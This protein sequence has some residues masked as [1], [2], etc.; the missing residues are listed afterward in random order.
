MCSVLF[1]FHFPVHTN[2][3]VKLNKIEEEDVEERDE[4]LLH[5]TIIIFGGVAA[6]IHIIIL[7]TLKYSFPRKYI[8]ICVQAA[9][10]FSSCMYFLFLNF[11][12]SIQLT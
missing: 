4:A 10:S 11:P 2:G 9:F 12:F 5:I 1:F 8:G 6:L 3:R 7:S